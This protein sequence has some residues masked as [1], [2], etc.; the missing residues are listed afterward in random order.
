[1]SVNINKIL[2]ADAAGPAW[3]KAYHTS[4]YALAGL[5]PAGLVSPEG[6]ALAKV[7]D[8]GLA[9]AIPFHTHVGLS[10]VVADYVPRALQTPARV[11]VLGLTTVTF[12]GLLKLSLTGNGVTGTIKQ[13]WKKQ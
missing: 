7:S 2:M 5:L 12:L 6:G 8:I 11:G 4:S 1:M 3:Q 10:I 9:A 13:L